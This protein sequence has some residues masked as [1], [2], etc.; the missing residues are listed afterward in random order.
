VEAVGRAAGLALTG[1]GCSQLPIM[2]VVPRQNGRA[3]HAHVGGLRT[4]HP[5]V[6]VMRRGGAMR[7]ATR[8]VIVCTTYEIICGI[9]PCIEPLHSRT[10]NCTCSSESIL[11]PRVFGIVFLGFSVMGREVHAWHQM[12]SCDVSSVDEC[13]FCLLAKLCAC[14]LWCVERLGPTKRDDIVV[15]L[16]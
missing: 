16:R 11:S 8:L 13:L 7:P 3:V 2:L 12:P 1:R 5:V 10:E 9:G 15:E 14:A 4:C 6:I